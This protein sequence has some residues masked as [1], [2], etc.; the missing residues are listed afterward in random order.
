MDEAALLLGY[1]FSVRHTVIAGRQ[2]G[3]ELGFPTANMKLC[4][5]TP[6]RNGV[7]AVR[8]RRADG[9]IYDGVA[10]LGLR[11]TIEDDGIQLLETHI[12]DFSADL[13]G[14][15]CTVSFFDFI[16]DEQKFDGLDALVLAIS[17][18]Q[19]HARSRLRSVEPVS[20]LDAA[21]NF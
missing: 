4:A 21:M 8:L 9:R 16:R 20:N 2:L 6:L 17:R 10:S 14:E 7:Y 18:D 19:D 15:A 12:F 11:P 13:Y 3:R 5:R 1:R